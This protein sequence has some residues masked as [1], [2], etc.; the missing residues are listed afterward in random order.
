MLGKT[1][2]T[3]D[4][5]EREIILTVDKL[6][7]TTPL[8]TFAITPTEEDQ[9]VVPPEGYAFSSGIVSAIPDRYQDTSSATAS[10]ADI[11][12]GKI[13]Y[14]T[15]GK[16]KGTIV[17]K[18]AT[19]ITPTT[20]DQ[21]ISSCQ[22]LA[23]DQVI[24]GDANLI[25]RNIREG[26]EIFGVPGSLSVPEEI[27]NQGVNFLDYDGKL[28]FHYEPDQLPLTEL[29]VVT[30]LPD[31]LEFAGWNWTLE[32]INNYSGEFVDVGISVKT[33]DDST[34][35]EV[36][37]GEDELTIEANLYSSSG[38]MHSCVVNW[39]DGTIEECSIEGGFVY[40]RF[41]HTYSAPGNY[42]IR[43]YNFSDRGLQVG[44]SS[45]STAGLITCGKQV[46]YYGNRVVR[47]AYLSA[48]SQ[49][50]I[51]SIN[52]ANLTHF[53]MSEGFNISSSLASTA[54]YDAV[55]TPRSLRTISYV[56]SP[57]AK[58]VITAG[59]IT[60]GSHLYSAAS[61]TRASVA[62]SATGQFSLADNGSRLTAFHMGGGV[63]T[64]L[65]FSGERIKLGPNVTSLLTQAF[66]YATNLKTVIFNEGLTTI[67]SNAFLYCPLEGVID[68]PSTITQID[69]NALSA[70]THITRYKIRALTPPTIS[71][72][73]FGV[74]AVDCPIEVPA[75]SYEA[76]INDTNWVS[77]ADWIVASEE[78]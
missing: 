23:G 4:G 57:M 64:A 46:A 34:I 35:I 65:Y 74:S 59:N 69:S 26:V 45:G 72:L 18:P 41:P 22:Y 50:S 66:M 36:E 67:G 16:L 30:D 14:G 75:A 12:E 40:S 51:R 9:P 19:V 62:D 31:F 21:T 3:I 71:S 63:A 60:S 73:S 77:Y 49:I 33:V 2:L 11:L 25:S 58:M 55:V 24:K 54:R 61:V 48:N 28:L 52:T 39:G 13:A 76:Y 68:L 27:P 43:F 47:S 1:I 44:H 8:T 7:T 53:V 70:N 38:G 20:T 42:L 29:P 56:T 6:A 78:F 32:E 10:S 15:G 37:L 17:S 5:G